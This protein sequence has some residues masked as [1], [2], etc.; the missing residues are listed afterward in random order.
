MSTDARTLLLVGARGFVGPWITRAARAEGWRVI[1]ASRRLVPAA[2]GVE[3]VSVD[4]NDTAALR[5]LVARSGAIVYNAAYLPG[6]YANP[7]DAEACVRVNALAL[8]G[9]L[10]L[11]TSCGAK[12]VIYL[13][14]GQG[15]F[16]SGRPAHE[17]DVLFPSHAAPYYLGSKLLGDLYAE[18]Y[19]I[20]KALPVTV[21][22]LGALY[23]PGQT[24]GVVAR[25]VERVQAGQCLEIQHGGRHASDLTFVG[26]AADAAMRVLACK[27]LGVFN[28]GS[29]RLTT[30]LEAARWIVAAAG[31]DESCLVMQPSAGVAPV[32][33]AALDVTR[34]RHELGYV[35][36][37]PQEGLARTV[38]EW[39]PGG[40]GPISVPN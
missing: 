16:D 14:T 29:G 15:Y 36:T 13:S 21:L 4:V 17:G 28:I 34:A 20:A 38:R 30:V 8:L 3:T 7:S 27:A 5:P 19:R 2:D 25:F 26:D 32:G 24:R 33:F 39:S 23:G 9:V 35:P 18:H 22:R 12:P 10:E 11:A 31:R 37:P 6:S 40:H 1:A